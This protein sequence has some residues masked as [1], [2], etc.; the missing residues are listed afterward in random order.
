MPF[1]GTAT[2][3][4][5]PDVILTAQHVVD[6]FR[7]GPAFYTTPFVLTDVFGKRHG[8]LIK[9]VL[10]EG[11]YHEG[12]QPDPREDYSLLQ[13][14]CKLPSALGGD[15]GLRP[16]QLT[17][18]LPRAGD[19]IDLLGYGFLAPD[20]CHRPIAVPASPYP[21]KRRVRLVLSDDW[22]F[23]LA[24]SEANPVF[25][26]LTCKGDSGMTPVWNRQ[27]FAVH[28]T[29]IIKPWLKRP[30][31]ADPRATDLNKEIEKLPALDLVAE[32]PMMPDEGVDYIS[33]DQCLTHEACNVVYAEGSRCIP[34]VPPLVCE[35]KP[36]AGTKACRC[37]AGQTLRIDI[38]QHSK[39]RCMP[40]LANDVRPS[41]QLCDNECYRLQCSDPQMFARNGYCDPSIRRQN[42][43]LGGCRCMIGSERKNVAA[44]GQPLDYRCVVQHCNQPNLCKAGPL[45][46]YC[47]PDAY[48]GEMSYGDCRCPDGQVALWSPS[49]NAIACMPCPP[50]FRALRDPLTRLTSCVDA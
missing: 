41:A 38:D 27:V 42:S 18:T 1:G 17:D 7:N 25:Q 13:L 48:V 24:E 3:V 31:F 30:I 34:P 16:L 36:I 45:G 21:H 4:N 33:G 37:P 11:K 44:A 43:L 35:G 8:A 6:G 26:N 29:S 9:K 5:R 47:D 2:L 14:R 46:S 12:L 49:A 10:A 39:V 22:V 20:Y 19:F 32:C 28:S 15:L 50:G 23:N 40:M